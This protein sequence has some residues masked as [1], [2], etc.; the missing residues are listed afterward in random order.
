MKIVKPLRL[1]LMSRPY[2]LR[3]RQRMG[4]G[5]FALAS[6]D[7]QPLLQP[8][9]DLW[10]LAGEVLGEEGVVDLGVPKPCAEF[11]VSGSVYTAHQPQ[12]ATCAAQVR[13]GD[14]SKSLMVFGDRYW[15]DDRPTDPQ[16]YEAMPLD[17]AHAYGGPSYPDNPNGRGADDE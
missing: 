11:L 5:V 8:E 15:L 7:A 14:L 2:R 17:W 16:P 9:A 6:L 3:G 1:S 12:P 13:V 4:L 10:Q